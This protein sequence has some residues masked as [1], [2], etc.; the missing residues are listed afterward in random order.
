MILIGMSH[1]IAKMHKNM[2]LTVLHDDMHTM[3]NAE[4]GSFHLRQPAPLLQQNSMILGVH[5]QHNRHKNSPRICS[6][7]IMDMLILCCLRGRRAGC[8]DGCT[9]RID[10]PT[11][12]VKLPTSRQRICESIFIA[13]C[14][15]CWPLCHLALGMC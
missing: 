3:Q 6:A 8:R 5:V 2:P 15:A 14:T 7:T 13:A 11:S 1:P 4:E 9:K 12:F 10:W